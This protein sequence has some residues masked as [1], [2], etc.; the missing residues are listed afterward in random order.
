MNF[1]A[2]TVEPG[3]YAGQGL[4]ATQ[5]V[6]YFMVAPIAL[7]LVISAFAI[8]TDSKRDKRKS[9]VDSID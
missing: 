2:T 8:A 7:F 6:L 5:T 3:M 9:V 4:T 1:L